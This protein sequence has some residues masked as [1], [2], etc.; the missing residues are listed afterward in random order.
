[1]RVGFACFLVSSCRP[2]HSLA[3]DW[4][5]TICH[6]ML[7]EPAHVYSPLLIIR[8][9]NDSLQS[10]AQTPLSGKVPLPGKLNVIHNP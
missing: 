5:Q 3:S 9:L 2:F 1:M 7:T 6:E 8:L 4:H 10:L